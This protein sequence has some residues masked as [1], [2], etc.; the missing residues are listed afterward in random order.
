MDLM[1]TAMRAEI[2]EL[3]EIA[4]GSAF[5]GGCTSLPPALHRSSRM[6][7]SVPPNSSE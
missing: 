7:W 3:I 5:R 4:S 1:L 6:L 2:E